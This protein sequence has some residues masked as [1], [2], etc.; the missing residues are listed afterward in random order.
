MYLKDQ[1]LGKLKAEKV[2]LY[3]RRLGVDKN[4]VTL[5]LAGKPIIFFDV[6]FEMTDEQVKGLPNAMF[7]NYEVTRYY[8]NPLQKRLS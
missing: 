6:S 8:E 2:I 1:Y 4:Q 3:I 5:S 7:E